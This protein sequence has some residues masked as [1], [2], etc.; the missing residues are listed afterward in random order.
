MVLPNSEFQMLAKQ[1]VP[2]VQWWHEGYGGNYHLL[3]LK[4][5]PEEGIQAW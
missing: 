1:E 4:P 3:D 2:L 5:P